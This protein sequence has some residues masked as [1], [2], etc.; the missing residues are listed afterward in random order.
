MIADLEK[1]MLDVVRMS[2]RVE[3]DGCGLDFGVGKPRE[4]DDGRRRRRGVD[5]DA[6]VVHGFCPRESQHVVTTVWMDRSASQLARS[7]SE[8]VI[9][10]R[11]WRSLGEQR[12]TADTT[13]GSGSEESN[14]SLQFGPHLTD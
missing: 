8:A 11:V 14:I 4:E 1:R 9:V 5:G 7:G 6:G 3:Y 13:S 12:H 2:G 10:T